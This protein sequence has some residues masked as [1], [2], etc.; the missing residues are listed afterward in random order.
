MLVR[1]RMGWEMNHRV[2]LLPS[3]MLQVAQTQ[4]K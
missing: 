4:S 2:L 1:K 3:Q